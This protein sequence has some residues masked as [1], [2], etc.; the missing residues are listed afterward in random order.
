MFRYFVCLKKISVSGNVLSFNLKLFWTKCII[1]SVIRDYSLR[2]HVANVSYPKSC[3]LSEF[4]VEISEDPKSHLGSST[5]CLKNSYNT[6]NSTLYYFAVY[7]SFVSPGC[8]TRLV[9]NAARIVL[10]KS[11]IGRLMFN[12]Q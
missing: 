2:N 12:S 7:S 10:F 11:T 9:I 6:G 8:L 1:K 3:K 5:G 4:S